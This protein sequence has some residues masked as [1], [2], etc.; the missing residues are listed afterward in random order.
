MA[1]PK[2]LP[3]PFCGEQP[4][5]DE[6]QERAFKAVWTVT[7]LR[8]VGCFAQVTTAGQDRATVAARWNRRTIGDVLRGHWLTGIICNHDDKTDV[9]T[10]SCSL[11]QCEPMPSVGAAVD[12]WIEHALTAPPPGTPP[13]MGRIGQ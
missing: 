7:R 13:D 2:L 9:A 12:A 10:C 11:W 6:Y 1:S 3:C 4:E 8:C 5:I